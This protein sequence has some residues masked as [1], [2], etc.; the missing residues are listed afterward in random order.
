MNGAYVRACAALLLALAMATEAA[1][2]VRRDSTRADTSAQQIDR[3]VVSSVR[4]PEVA[5]GA[6]VLEIKP[7]S[8]NA[9]PAPTLQEVLRL[10]PFVLV[11]QN[12]RGEVELSMRGSESRQMAIVVDGLPITIGWDSRSDPSLIPMT[13]VQSVK[14]VRG[15]SSLLH[16]PN[17]LGGILEMALGSGQP[18]DSRQLMFSSGVDADG[19][20][21]AD[22]VGGR[23]I[24]TGGGTLLVR[25]G[26]GVRDR[27]QVSLPGNH[28]FLDAVGGFAVL[29]IGYLLA[30]RFT[31]AG[32]A[33]P[34]ELLSPGSGP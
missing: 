20:I 4:S 11:R 27:S 30:Y 31:R 26:G 8:L 18:V 5:G 9:P 22:V 7:F 28:Y 12:S 33:A 25:G 14:L 24:T 13:G 15:L 1:A 29:G 10:T 34:S 17:V 16:G 3:V 21:A 6:A 19:A 32:R 23:S 2:Q